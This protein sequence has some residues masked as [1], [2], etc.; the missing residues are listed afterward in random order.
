MKCIVR[1]CR[2]DKL[3]INE[4]YRVAL[5]TE[6]VRINEILIP[7]ARDLSDKD[8]RTLSVLCVG[9]LLNVKTDVL[10]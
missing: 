1:A 3:L 7:A 8:F 9:D 10:K 4:L 6:G 2:N 5:K